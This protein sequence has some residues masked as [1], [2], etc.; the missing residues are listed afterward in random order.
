[1][2]RIIFGLGVAGTLGTGPTASAQHPVN[3]ITPM[4]AG[5]AVQ[6]W[7]PQPVNSIVPLGAGNTIQ[8][9]K[10]LGCCPITPVVVNGANP[11]GNV[12]ATGNRR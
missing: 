12:I 4:G 7:R 11:G 3:P 10:P 6:G 5:N 8:G 2:R 9:V 1:M